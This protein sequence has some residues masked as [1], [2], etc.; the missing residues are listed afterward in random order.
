[1]WGS[2]T[3]TRLR[4][5]ALWQS[6]WPFLESSQ[7]SPQCKW[8]LTLASISRPHC[9]RKGTRHFR[10]LS[11][12]L[13]LKL[14]PFRFGKIMFSVSFFFLSLPLS[15]SLSAFPQHWWDHN[16][17]SILGLETAFF[18]LAKFF[19]GE[20]IHLLHS[21]CCLI[22]G[23][24]DGTHEGAVL[25]TT[26]AGMWNTGKEVRA[27]EM[28]SHIQPCAPVLLQWARHG[29]LCWRNVRDRCWCAIT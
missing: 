16:G 28:L 3:W 23:A 7:P 26:S 8:G 22:H 21:W 1:M 20:V 29:H 19:A 6:R 15:L 5:A 2:L 14:N 27:N 12:L 9:Y 13:P 4:T 25:H 24:V 11:Q 10:L 17:L 18:L